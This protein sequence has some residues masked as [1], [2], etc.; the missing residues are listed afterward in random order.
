MGSSPL[1]RGKRPLVSHPRAVSGLIP[2]HAGKTIICDPSGLVSKAH[3]RS[4]GEN[5]PRLS[6]D[7]P[8]EGSSPLTRGKRS[9]AWSPI[10]TPGL[11]PAHAGK[12][13]IWSR[14]CQAPG[15][16]PRSRGENGLGRRG[17][18]ADRGSSPLTRGKRSGQDTP[19]TGHRAHPRSRG[20]NLCRIGHET[21]VPGS[22]PLTRGKLTPH[23]APPGTSGLIPAHAGKTPCPASSHS[24]RRA[25]PRS[26][27]ENYGCMG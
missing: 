2:A 7:A 17:N 6:V 20:E 19:T 22:S 12:T 5:P 25:H 13:S 26:R 4:R 15:A 14:T 9:R 8:H 16:H 24:S 23:G 1:T 18:Q 21:E 10:P 11:I 3:P 27:G